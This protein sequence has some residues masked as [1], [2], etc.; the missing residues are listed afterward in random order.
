MPRGDRG[1][2]GVYTKLNHLW[3]GMEKKRCIYVLW[4]ISF[5][6]LPTSQI[7]L[8]VPCTHVSGPILLASL[9]C[10]LDPTHKWDTCIAYGH[11]QQHGEGPGKGWSLG[12]CT[13]VGEGDISHSV[14]VKKRRC[15]MKKEEG[16]QMRRVSSLSLVFTGNSKTRNLRDMGPNLTR[17]TSSS[18]T[19]YASCIWPSNS[20]R[21]TQENPLPWRH[22]RSGLGFLD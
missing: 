12:G 13:E 4:P 17:L 10:S 15:T 5:D 20:S 14:T 18:Q 21:W 6:P 2:L 22:P 3:I 9:F 7:C 19:V 8:S 1:K 16:R 11:R